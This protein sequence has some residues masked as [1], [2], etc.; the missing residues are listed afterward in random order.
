MRNLTIKRQKSFVA[1]LM[2]VQVYIEDYTCQDTVI[3]DVPCRKLG[4]LKNN[5]EKTFAIGDNEAKVFVIGDKLSKGFCNDYYTVPAGIED[6]YLTGKN[7]YNPLNGNAFLFDG[8]TDEEALK[9][10][11]KSKKIG[12]IVLIVAV[13]V[14]FLLGFLKGF[15]EDYAQPE[16]FVLDEMSITL[17][18]QFEKVETLD[19]DF[20]LESNDVVVFVVKEDFSLLEDFGELTLEEYG[21]LVIENN[22]LSEVSELY[23]DEE[24][25]YFDYIYEDDETGLDIYYLSY[26]YKSEQAFWVVQFSVY[27]KESYDYLD[28]FYEWASS[29]EFAK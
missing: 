22:G 21:E 11:K 7:R 23:E 10:R 14:G 1:S 29:V 4:S 16:T 6:I 9:N 26:V 5:E 28:S 8:V 20:T 3:K 27:D 18:D 17:T 25:L 24:L 15:F 2:K 19:S 13:I 12:T